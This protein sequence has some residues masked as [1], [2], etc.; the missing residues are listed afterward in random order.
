MVKD[1]IYCRPIGDVRVNG[2]SHEPRTYEVVGE[3]G[4]LPGERIEAAT[5]GFNLFLDPSELNPFEAE[6][7]RQALQN[8]LQALGGS[9]SGTAGGL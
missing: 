9:A 7:A 5:D 8:A 3:S 2:V 4:S 6:R 1:E